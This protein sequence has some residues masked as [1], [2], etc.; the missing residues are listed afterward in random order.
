MDVALEAHDNFNKRVKTKM[1]R[2]AKKNC[3]DIVRNMLG[4]RLFA[5]FNH[6][7]KH[8]TGFK[9]QMNT[10]I[11]DR[12]FMMYRGYMLSYFNHWR[13]NATQKKIRK[14]KKMIMQAQEQSA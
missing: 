13:K 11:K 4:K 3:G 8:T 9:A 2:S 10:K 6:W 5:Y 1:V 12:I 14:R 7:K